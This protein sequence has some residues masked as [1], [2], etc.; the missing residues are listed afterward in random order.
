LHSLALSGRGPGVLTATDLGANRKFHYNTPFDPDRCQGGKEAMPR[1]SRQP[2]TSRIPG[3]R[4]AA[5]MGAGIASWVRSTAGSSFGGGLLAAFF[6]VA[7]CHQLFARFGGGLVMSSGAA[8]AVGVGLLAAAIEV[9][10]VSRSRR[11]SFITVLTLAVWACALGWLADAAGLALR[12]F[13]LESL[14][15]SAAQFEAAYGIALLLLAVPAFCAARLALRSFTLDGFW[16]CAGGAAGCLT[17]AYGF[18][19]WFGAQGTGLITAG[20]T[21]AWAVRLYV[22]RGVEARDQQFEGTVDG[23]TEPAVSIRPTSLDFARVLISSFSAGLAAAALAR[24]VEQLMPGTQ[25]IAWTCC[26]GFCLGAALSWRIVRGEYCEPRF[27]RAPFAVLIAA[28]A[29]ALPLVLFGSFTDWFLAAT[30]TLSSV[31]LL[32]LVRG[33]VATVFLFAPGALW[34]AVVDWSTPNRSKRHPAL[35]LS[36]VPALLAGLI[37]APWLVLRGVPVPLLIAAGALVPATFAVGRAI[38]VSAARSRLVSGVAWTAATAVFV[39]S[40]LAHTYDPTRSARLLFSTNVFVAWRAATENRLL[41]FLD[42][43]RLVINR[44]GENG[45]Y[46][47]WKQRGLQLALR[48]S[49]IPCGTFSPRPEIGPQF[50]GEIVPCLLP[51]VLHEAPRHMLIVGLGAGS[52]LTACLEFPIEDVTCIEGDRARIDVLETAVWPAAVPNPRNDNRVRVVC[53]EPNL[54]LES[55]RG[56]YDIVYA[57]SGQSGVSQG[58]AHYTREFYAAAARQLAY[59]GIFAQRFQQVDFGPWPLQSA[60]A[61]LKSVFAHVAAIEVAPGE[62]ALLATQSDK[63]LGR[64]HLLARFQ[65]PQARRTL[66]HLGWDW[67]IVLNLAAY[68][69]KGGDALSRGATLNTAANGLFAFRLPQETM[70][71][72][73]KNEELVA[74]LSPTA[75]RMAQWPHVDGNDPLFLRRLSDVMRE[76]DLMTSYPDQPWAYRQL[77]KEELTKHPHTT[78]EDGENGFERRLDPVDRQRVDYFATLGQAAKTLRPTLE[79]LQ[80]VEEFAEPYDPVLTYFLHHELAALYARSVAAGSSA[81]L[82]HRLYTVYYSDPRDRSVRDVV[83]ALEI[84]IHEPQLVPA[85]QRWDFLNALLAFLEMRW[86]NRGLGKPASPQVVLNDLERSIETAEST[87]TLM[88]RLHDSVGVCEA[89]WSARRS[90]LERGIVRPL[91]TYRAELVPVY[92]KEGDKTASS[93]SAQPAEPRPSAN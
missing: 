31:W 24:V 33:L 15:S 18:A 32:F 87:L 35:L 17:A 43:G 6:A 91:R 38:R 65:T 92:Q 56:K 69:G 9:R 20:A 16:V 59:D 90:V 55:R 25:A 11:L 68:S 3:A 48:E 93:E 53:C 13:D 74:A 39:V 86:T 84:L 29:C 51:L 23:Q 83:D 21:I 61:T 77:I 19:P 67:S 66:A 78:V 73:P 54:A 52:G 42:D 89:D 63:G 40:I 30:A 22:T 10:I 2:I 27:T 8:T 45:T 72:G 71:W 85:D 47:V 60:L 7:F 81:Q 80:R 44:E 70:R 4:L 64:P 5:W 62:L 1:L 12:S 79:S 34:S 41:P 26:A 88:D 82:Q 76:H 36:A 75:G 14:A 49:G 46:T 28:L 37:A 50:S 58:T 57:D